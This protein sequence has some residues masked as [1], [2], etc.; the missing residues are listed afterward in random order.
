[1][2]ISSFD[3]SSVPEN[4]EKRKFH[5][6]ILL[7]TTQ[8]IKPDFNAICQYKA[9]MS[10]EPV[11]PSSIYFD[12]EIMTRT[13]GD[14]TKLIDYLRRHEDLDLIESDFKIF[15]NERISGRDH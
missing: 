11:T 1:M 13:M 4:G 12:E 8:C 10:S 15:R 7:H 14:V 3:L 9:T 6:S 2:Y 5:F